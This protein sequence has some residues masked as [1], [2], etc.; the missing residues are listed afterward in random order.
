MS[1]TLKLV[2]QFS[3]YRAAKLL[4][5][6]HGEDALIR[7]AER[8]DELLEEGDTAGFSRD[9]SDVVMLAT[10]GERCCGSRGPRWPISARGRDLEQL[11]TDH[12]EE[13]G[14]RQHG[15]GA[16]GKHGDAPGC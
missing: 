15:V 12:A 16:R 1:G 14:N 6:Q 7:A 8:A 4:I 2:E 9:L 10:K 5:D 11:L 13:H 3:L